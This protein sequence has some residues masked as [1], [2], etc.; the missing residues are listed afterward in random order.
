MLGLALDFGPRPVEEAIARLAELSGE[1]SGDRWTDAI[2][3]IWLGRL[4]AMRANF[5]VARE[6]VA[7]AQTAFSDLGAD[8]AVVDTCGR[9]TAA[10]ELA[11]GFPDVAARSLRDACAL[12]EDLHQ[13]SVLATRAAELA[14]ALYE[15]GRYDEASGWAQVAGASAGDDDLDAILTRQPVEAKIHARLGRVDDAERLA[16]A[17]VDLAARTDALNRRA[18]SL[19]ALAEVL[20]LTG[21]EQEAQEH[22]A[23]AL[24][25]YEQKGNVA[26]ARRVRTKHEEPRAGL[27][28]P[29]FHGS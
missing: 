28:V 2:V 29:D 10:V 15:L 22:V 14:H 19:L 16:R 17:V 20:E 6:H 7:R 1:D 13:T 4:E 26:A 21:A 3:S 24:G 12:L 11:A 8:T 25:F 5:D 27:F 23:A 18:E 9:A